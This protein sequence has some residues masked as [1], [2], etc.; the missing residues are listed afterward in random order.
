[1]PARSRCTPGPRAAR[2][3]SGPRR[4]SREVEEFIKKTIP[5]HDLELIVSELGVNADWSAAYTPNAGP[6]DAVVKVQLKDERSTRLRSMCT[7]CGPGVA[8]DPRFQDLDFGFDAGGMVR[9][10]MNEG[11]STPIN[12]RVTGKNQQHGPR[13]RRAIQNEVHRR[14]T[15]SSTPG[16]SSGS[17]IPSSSSTSTAPRRPTWD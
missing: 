8:K 15:A 2:A 11:K 4:R 17:I 6:M 14:S 16:S 5:E 13:D 1:M 10:A 3:S 12:I 9:G 7:C